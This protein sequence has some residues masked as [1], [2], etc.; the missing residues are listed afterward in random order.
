MSGPLPGEPSSGAE[1]GAALERGVGVA[2]IAGYALT[3]LL[4]GDPY[5]LLWAC[6]FGLFLSG[7]ALLCRSVSG[8][9]AAFL[10]VAYGTSLWFLDALNGRE[11]GPLTLAVH[12]GGLGV[13]SWS[14]PSPRR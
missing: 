14:G 12:L 9:G 13:A 1:G 11:L 4:D 7:L 5:D 3:P 2:A 10:W 8:S 6:H